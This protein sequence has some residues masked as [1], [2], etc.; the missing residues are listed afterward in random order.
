MT[1]EYDKVIEV[2]NN[3]NLQAE[4][5]GIQIAKILTPVFQKLAEACTEL[6]RFYIKLQREEMRQRLV[7][8]HVP[9]WIAGWIANWWPKR[10]LPDLRDVSNE[11]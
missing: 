5:L 3:F 9:G 1:I 4:V 7:S 8:R 2:V 11:P 10:W 6:Y